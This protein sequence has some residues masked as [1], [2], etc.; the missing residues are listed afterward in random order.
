MKWIRYLH[1]YSYAF[2]GPNRYCLLACSRILEALWPCLPAWHWFF[3]RLPLQE[4]AAIEMT[5]KYFLLGIYV[6]IMNFIALW[7]AG[8]MAGSLT[9]CATLWRIIHVRTFVHG[10]ANLFKFVS[11]MIAQI[12][13]RANTYVYG[14][15]TRFLFLNIKLETITFES[16]PA[17]RGWTS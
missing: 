13:K 9:H 5:E 14:K 7:L 16:S 4:E 15:C 6:P 12:V 11:K 10:Y 3:T 17:L 1:A 2:L 8:W